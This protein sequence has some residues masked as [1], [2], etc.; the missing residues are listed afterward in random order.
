MASRSFCDQARSVSTAPV[1]DDDGRAD[2][3]GAR[4]ERGVEAAGDAEADQ[5]GAAG[6]D[7]ALEVGGQMA[8]VAAA[9][10]RQPAAGRDAGLEC[11]TDDNNHL[12]GPAPIRF[13]PR[14]GAP[15]HPR[16]DAS[17]KSET[18]RSGEC[19]WEK[20]SK[21]RTTGHPTGKSR[22][23]ES[24]PGKFY[25]LARPRHPFI[26]KTGNPLPLAWD[27]CG[28][29]WPVS[30]PAAQ[31]SAVSAA[32]IALAAR[33]AGAASPSAPARPHGR[34]QAAGGNPASMWPA[35][36]PPPASRTGA[37]T[38]MRGPAPNGR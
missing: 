26:P 3:A 22:L 35:R 36:W 15:Q 7:G 20:P 21:C 8:S 1:A 10:D 24:A 29:S 2:H 12:S 5:P 23:R 13:S 34:A 17:F 30:G 16:N 33:L 19:S 38:Q 11:Q 37:P 9:Y 28:K 6:G 25:Q 14:G 4:L 27:F 32:R 31:A 18:F